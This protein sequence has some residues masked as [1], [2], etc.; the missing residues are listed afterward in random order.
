VQ[1]SP[2]LGDVDGAG[3]VQDRIQVALL[4]FLVLH[5]TTPWELKP[6]CARRDPGEHRADLRACHQLG[7]LHRLVD[8][9]TVASM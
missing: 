1:D 3:G 9:R 2:V 7:F 6:G 5:A 8:R 4:H